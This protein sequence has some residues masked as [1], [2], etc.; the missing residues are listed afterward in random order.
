MCIYKYKWDIKS[1]KRYTLFLCF[2]KLSVEFGS[3]KI[4]NDFLFIY[5][6][7]NKTINYD[8]LITLIDNISNTYNSYSLIINKCFSIIY[9]G[10]IAEENK[11]YTKLGKRIKRLGIHKLLF[12]NY[13]P[14]NA[15]NFMKGKTW[16]EIDFIC[17]QYN[18]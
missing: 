14:E 4:Y 11:L 9:L 2:K 8:I 7:T 18:F 5:K 6:N 3:H 10:M 1:S 15:A 16:K 13:E 12:E 17:K